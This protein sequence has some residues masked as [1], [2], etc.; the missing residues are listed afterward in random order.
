M[1]NKCASAKSRI[2]KRKRLNSDSRLSK[3]LPKL[4]ETQVSEQEL[5]L[6]RSNPRCSGAGGQKRQREQPGQRFHD[7][8]AARRRARTR[9]IDATAA[10]ATIAA[11]AGHSAAVGLT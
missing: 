10:T 2:S 7:R 9:T 8:T 4:N 1:S 6:R 11:S 3:H 5:R